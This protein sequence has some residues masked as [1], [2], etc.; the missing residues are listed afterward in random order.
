MH[1]TTEFDQL[2]TTLLWASVDG[3]D[4]KL[5]PESRAQIESDYQV[6]CDFLPES[7]DPEESCLTGGDPYEQFAHDY[8]LTRMGAGVGFWETADWE[9]ESGKKLTELCKEQGTIET[10]VG[11]DNKLYVY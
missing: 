8:I 1:A 6:F 2:A 4:V 3:S 5:D 9:E 11:D 7:F 10:Y